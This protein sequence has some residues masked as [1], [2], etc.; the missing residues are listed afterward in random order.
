[1]KNELETVEKNLSNARESLINASTP[2]DF[3]KACD[4]FWDAYL[5]AERH[6]IH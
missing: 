3:D 6:G 5:N 4:D 1:M 2:D